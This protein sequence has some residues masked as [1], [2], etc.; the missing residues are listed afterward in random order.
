P[1]APPAPALPPDA[2]LPEPPGPPP[3]FV[4]SP[5]HAAK[6]AATR[7]ERPKLL[8]ACTPGFLRLH[9]AYVN[10][11][12]G[13]QLRAASVPNRVGDAPRFHADFPQHPPG[14]HVKP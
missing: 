3:P 5:P 6:R 13:S 1:P 14:R 12:I 7:T 9:L 8:S 10:W 11:R 4:S 2:P